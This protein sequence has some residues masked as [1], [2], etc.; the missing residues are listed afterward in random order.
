M[1]GEP[2]CG[3]SEISG[4]GAVQI[5]FLEALAARLL[6]DPAA[7]VDISGEMLEGV[8]FRDFL[9]ETEARAVTDGLAR[10][11]NRQAIKA[12]I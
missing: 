1:R 12:T 8:V 5:R 10:A 9:S 11:M 7:D 3:L 2:S 6:D 4:G